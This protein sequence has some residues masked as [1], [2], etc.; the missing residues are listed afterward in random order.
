MVKV[1]CK[2]S[3]DSVCIIDLILEYLNITSNNRYLLL[4][5]VKVAPILVL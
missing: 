4:G 2:M 5:F 3:V 1:T